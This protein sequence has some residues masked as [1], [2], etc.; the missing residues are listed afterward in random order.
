M[1]HYALIAYVAM[2]LITSAC[3]K[4]D[5]STDVVAEEQKPEHH[6]VA[7]LV[8]PVWKPGTLC[9]KGEVSQGHGVNPKGQIVSGCYQLKTECGV[10]K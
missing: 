4:A 5:A 3:H 6:C 9:A 1:K 8:G 2:S 7:K 10:E